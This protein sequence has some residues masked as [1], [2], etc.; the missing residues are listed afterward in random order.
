MSGIE[1]FPSVVADIMSSP[2]I[3]IGVDAK[4]IDAAKIM[5]GKKIGSIIIME[6]DRAVGIVTERDLLERVL[7]EGKDPSKVVMRDVMSSPLISIG[8]N[9]AILEAMR[10]MRRHDIRRLTVIEGEQLIGIVTE[11]DILKAVVTLALAS[12]R[13]LLEK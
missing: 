5:A 13:P 10:V 6:G 11:R 2:V 8:K 1:R 4:V 9:T 3:T 12:F 7:G